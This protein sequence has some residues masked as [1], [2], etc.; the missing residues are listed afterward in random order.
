[1]W[2][3]TATLDPYLFFGFLGFLIK[4]AKSLIYSYP[5][6]CSQVSSVLQATRILLRVFDEAAKEF[7][8]VDAAMA[9][10]RK[11]RNP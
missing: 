10:R 3:F 7:E 8:G 4:A 1:M 6:E 5:P 9:T 11:S 2:Y